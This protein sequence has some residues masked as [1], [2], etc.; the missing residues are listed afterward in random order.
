MEKI[1]LYFDGYCPES[2]LKGK[3]MAQQRCFCIL[4]YT[5]GKKKN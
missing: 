1:E 3:Q 2:M 5:A 4:F